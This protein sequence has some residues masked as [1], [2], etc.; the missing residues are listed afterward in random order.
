MILKKVIIDGKEVFQPIEFKEALKYKI[1]KDLIFTDEDEKED[2]FDRL[3]EIE[4]EAE[5]EAERLEQEAEEEA[6]ILEEAEEETEDSDENS[7]EE[8]DYSTNF[9]FKDLGD[10]FRDFF[11]NKGKTAKTTKLLVTLPFM[12]QEDVHE[13]VVS[14][15]NN[16]EGYKDIN[17]VTVMPF[18]SNDDCDSLFMKLINDNESC[19]T[20]SE[21]PMG[22]FISK[23]C[24][25]NLVD[26]YI[27]GNYQHVNMDGLYPF[28][29]SKDVKKVFKYILNKEEVEEESN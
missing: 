11:K 14:I 15:L 25:T 28:M 3:E 7:N 9:D 26:E 8:T 6:E 10:K 2:F 23:E 17:L 29:D 16:E 4:E 19:Y 21:I 18:L 12:S 1:K 20:N 27:K 5:E 13:V 24:F 22:P